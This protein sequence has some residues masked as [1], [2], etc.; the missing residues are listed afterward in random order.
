MVWWD[1]VMLRIA[2]PIVLQIQNIVYYFGFE[3]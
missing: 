2:F 3:E 1:A